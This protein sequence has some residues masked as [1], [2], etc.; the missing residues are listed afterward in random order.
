MTQEP[1][2]R[3]NPN[4]PELPE[5]PRPRQRPSFFK[6]QTIKL[7]RGTIALLEGTVENLE[8]DPTPSLLPP[9]PS[10][11]RRLLRPLRILLPTS[12]NRKISDWGL[13]GA[14]A[15]LLVLVGWSAIAFL[16]PETTE[17]IAQVTPEEPTEIVEF[18]PVESEKQVEEIPAIE[19][20]EIPETPPE[21][22]EF[23][24]LE[25]SVDQSKD[26]TNLEE[27]EEAIAESEL[28]S[29][30]NFIEEIDEIEQQFPLTPEQ[31]LTAFIEE[32]VNQLTSQ[33]AD[34]ILQSIKANFRG[35]SLL[36]TVGNEWYE[37]L[38]NTQDKLANQM[39]DQAHGL[40]FTN[41]EIIDTQEN[42]VARSPS[43][44]SQMIILRR[45]LMELQL[46]Y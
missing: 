39:L 15:A 20:P 18:P 30:E 2:N 14:I 34:G 37:L 23:P 12:I 26:K 10:S 8:A 7:L 16:P 27:P 17:Q 11:L 43:V 25:P 38:E 46:D 24:P 42:L 29:P 6:Q 9:F 35:S 21:E 32:E 31:I 40:D 45:S 4:T 41:L 33:Y 36:V 3:R 1:P 5:T 22:I 28:E 13:T 44:G 19:Q